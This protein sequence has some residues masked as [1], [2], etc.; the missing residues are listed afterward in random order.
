MLK[1]ARVNAR[2]LAREERG[3]ALV[4]TALVMATL[5]VVSALAIDTAIWFVHGRHLQTQADAAAFAGGDA[6]AASFENGNCSDSDIKAVIA[7]YDGSQTAGASLLPANQQVPV[8]PT[9]SNVYSPTAHN[10]FDQVNQANFKNQSVPADTGLTGSPCSD[11]TV[12]VKMTES[13]LPSFLTALAPPYINKQA[14]VMA[15]TVATQGSTPFVLPNIQTPKDVAAFVVA[16]NATTPAFST[17]AILARIGSCSSN[18]NVP[19]C[20]ASSNGGATWI[21][22]SVSVP[23]SATPA[24]LVV[25]QSTSAISPSSL[26]GV[27]SGASLATFCAST[28][29]SCYDGTDGTGLT[30]T[31]TYTASTANFPTQAPVVQDTAVSDAPTDPTKQCQSSGSTNLF[32]G[33]SAASSNCTV[34]FSADMNFGTGTNS[35]C[36]SL[37]SLG[38][39]LTIT[40]SSG[41]SSTLTCP[42]TGGSA[43]PG[44][45][46]GNWTTASTLSLPPN[47]GPVTFDL[48]WSRTGG[49][50]TV[51]MQT[52]ETGGNA[53]KCGSGSN[54]CKADFK[55]VQRLFTGAYDQNTASTSHSGSVAGAALT[56]ASGVLMSTP[57]NQTLTN[58]GVTIDF[59]ALYD[60]SAVNGYVPS[61]SYTDIAYGTNQGNGL[62][63]CGQG[64]SNSKGGNGFDVQ[65][66]AIAG[67]FTCTNYPII[68]APTACGASNCPNTVPGN[69]F[70]QWLHGGMATRI[71]GCPESSKQNQDGCSSDPLPAASC[72][73]HPNYWST[74]NLMSGVLSNSSDP[75]LITVMVTDPGSLANGNHNVPVRHY[76]AFYVTGWTG[77]PCSGVSVSG[78]TAST[79]LYYVSADTAPTDSGGDFFLVGHFVKYFTSGTGSGTTC[80]MG[81]IDNCTLTVT[82]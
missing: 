49:G 11:A 46:N 45:A 7:Q 50:T 12:D 34:N 15:Q 27:T 1:K 28:G 9:F 21:A 56:G 25:V 17:D 52:W 70:P 37:A 74:Q 51:P 66:N 8:T 40:A 24:S 42:N 13:N 77:D 2:A 44:S 76:A 55:V 69:K 43:A 75:R 82:K 78:R 19:P 20:L 54:A 67:L 6:M 58:L 59:Q 63:D 47:A 32:T 35:S 81:S 5:F 4:I 16:E 61:G 57:A 36:S 18:G 23:F 33:F 3:V 38:V 30:Y 53:G 79:G 48:T 10:L 80:S 73:A 72:A 26:S 71:Y 31:R 60:T 65:E 39:T 68:P 29:I 64:V 62:G 14:A 41:G 22:G